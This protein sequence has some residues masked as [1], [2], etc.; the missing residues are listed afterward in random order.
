MNL[1]QMIGILRT[2]KEVLPQWSPP[3]ITRSLANVFV[4]VLADHTDD[5]IQ[6]AFGLAVGTL[7][8]WPAPATIKRLCLGT[9]QNDEELA[10]DIAGRIWGAIVD[11]G[12]PNAIAAQKRI[13]EL[14]WEVVKQNGGWF[15]ICEGATF[16]NQPSL[17]KQWRET[18]M[19]L[20]KRFHNRG[21]DLPP[22]LPF[23]DRSDALKRALSI[24]RGDEDAKA[25]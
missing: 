13:G 19:S 17:M 3:E 20:S 8:E 2:T 22:A 18:A 21:Y 5:E 11:C 7:T 1:D 4:Q 9:D 16:K 12:R 6:K 25:V 10:A 23:G 14:G 15:S 24:A